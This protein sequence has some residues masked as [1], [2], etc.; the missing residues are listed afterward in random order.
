MSIK[1]I[2]AAAIAALAFSF[3]AKAQTNVQTFYDFGKD[4]KYVTTTFEMFKGDKFGDTFFFIDHYYNSTDKNL[5]GL[6]N[7]GPAN[8]SYFEI[9]RGINFWQDSDL[10]DFSLHLEYDG[11]IT[12]G[13]FNQGTYCFGAK[14]FF[15]S[16]D[17][18][19]TLSLY[20]MYEHFNSK[21][22]PKPGVPLKF[23]AVWGL[24]NLFGVK[25]LTFKGF[26]DFWGNKQVWGLGGK[27]TGWS[28]LTEPQLWMNLGSAF[29]NHL[30]LG[31]EIE[32][33]N[34]FVAEGFL[35]NPCLGLRWAF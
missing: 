22:T 3:S 20:A 34:N 8:G 18:S 10:K 31:C 12:G 32:I 15:H 9:E 23:T 13:G 1:P 5:K 17:F 30:D 16:Q 26:A 25:G 27:E 24:N 35:V 11:L 19:K 4:R 33:S 7:S 21:V 14:Y 29:D 2:I 28:F 6:Q